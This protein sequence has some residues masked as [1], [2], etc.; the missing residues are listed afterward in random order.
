MRGTDDSLGG[1]WKH[2][3]GTKD[4][5][6]ADVVLYFLATLVIIVSA[7]LLNWSPSYNLETRLRFRNLPVPT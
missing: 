5:K 1:I 4:P 7:I 3:R 2:R 6:G